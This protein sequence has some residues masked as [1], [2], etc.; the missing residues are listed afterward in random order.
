MKKKGFT[1][2][3]LLA[4]IVVISIIGLITVPALSNYIIKSKKA[5]YKISVQT[6]MEAAKEYV[7]KYEENNDF[8][9]GGI[10]ITQIDLN[11]KGNQFENGIIKKNEFGEIEAVNV[12]DGEYCANGT[13]QNL[14]VEKVGS[15]EE[16]NKV[17]ASK[18]DLKIK[19]VNIGST[20]INVTAIAVDNQSGIKDYKYCIGD[21]CSDYIKENNYEFKNLT[22]GTE[23]EI[24]VIVR[25]NNYGK[26]EQYTEE[27]T[28][29][30][31]K[32]KVKTNKVNAPEFKISS[33]S[34]A[35]SK[36]VTI[37]Y[38]IVEGYEKSYEIIDEEGN[39]IEKKEVT[40]TELTIL[41]NK[42]CV[43]K[44]NVTNS[45]E[46]ISNE[47]IITGIDEDAP[48]VY[49][50][51]S[52]TWERPKQI[53]AIVKENGSG[54]AS[55]AYSYNGGKSWIN[56]N[57]K[58]FQENT[59]IKLVVRDKLNNQTTS[60]KICTEKDKEGNP[61]NC[62][63]LVDEIKV[64]KI[65]TVK[66]TCS[67]K[68]TS[69]L[70]GVENWYRSDV[71]VDFENIDDKALDPSDETKLIEGSGVVE[72]YIDKAT[73]TE[74][75]KYKVTGTVVDKLGNTGTCSIDVNIDKS[76]PIVDVSLNGTEYGSG[77]KS[78]LQVTVTCSDN[79]SGIA[80]GNQTVTLTDKGNNTVS[81]TCVNKSGLTTD[82][83]YEYL[84]YVYTADSSACGTTQQDCNP[85]N[86]NPYSCNW[87]HC[88]TGSPNACQGGYVTDY[89]NCTQYRCT[90]YKSCASSSCGCAKYGV[91]YVT[92][93]ACRNQCSESRSYPSP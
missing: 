67:L 74:E 35:T 79:E 5:S 13:K 75:G 10:D 42:N 4:V 82:Y 65:D 30:T 87:D 29:N 18:P 50:I 85:Y 15:L 43:L 77:Y 16:C 2:I 54:L 86:C 32:I 11:L 70:M 80:S 60:Y 92:A 44:A 26:G 49:V 91:S 8:P 19:V 3:E 83:S 93:K 58:S 39:L 20:K 36:E 89:S 64:S 48:V 27:V 62:G 47:L 31:K 52:D 40:E 41:V 28:T 88:L 23:Y 33:S 59:T 25:N 55:K 66:P 76:S 71:T 72:S 38:P 24:T 6:T 56:N 34:Y 7:G 63:E 51:M 17:D 53:E 57:K 37:I 69:G 12:Y 81:G 9:E 78:G 61:I 45:E 73:L 46:T 22:N 1:L 84:I 14:V 90:L 68:V 21:E